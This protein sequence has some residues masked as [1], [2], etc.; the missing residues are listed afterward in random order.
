VRRFVVVSRVALTGFTAVAVA[1]LGA[2]AASEG[3]AQAQAPDPVTGSNM[4]SPLTGLNGNAV[5][6]SGTSGS[7]LGNGAPGCDSAAF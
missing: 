7:Q 4:C 6:G 5:G 1:A 2:L 3:T